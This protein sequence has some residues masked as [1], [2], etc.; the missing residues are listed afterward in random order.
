MRGRFKWDPRWITVRFPAT[1]ARPGCDVPITPGERAFH[2]PE[3]RTLYGLDAATGEEAARE[4]AA[5]RLDQ[6]G[7]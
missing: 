2:Y 5:H 6:D 3:D 7:F 1:C 4:F